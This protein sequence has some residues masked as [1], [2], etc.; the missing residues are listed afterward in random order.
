MNPSKRVPGHGRQNYRPGHGGNGYQQRVLEVT[1]ETAESPS[2]AYRCQVD[3]LEERER[4]DV[5]RDWV[6]EPSRDNEY[7]W[8]QRDRAEQNQDRVTAAGGGQPSVQRGEHARVF[9][10]APT[11]ATLAP[12]LTKLDEGDCGDQAQDSYQDRDRGSV[13]YAV[14]LEGL[15]VS[16]EAEHRRAVARPPIGHYDDEVDDVNPPMSVIEA[17]SVNTGAI[18][19]ITTYR[20]AAAS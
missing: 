17:T 4:I 15:V 3:V 13:P 7:E 20:L 9:G 2:V 14:A 19:G 1:A 11:L 16:V 8:V 5:D 10:G 6:P 18:A 12:S